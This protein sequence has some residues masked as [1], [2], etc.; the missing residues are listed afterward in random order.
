VLRTLDEVAKDQAT[1]RVRDDVER[2]DL[3]RQTI[4][5]HL[6]VLFGRAADGE[7]IEREHSGHRYVRA[8]RSKNADAA[9]GRNAAAAFENVPW[10]SSNERSGDTGL[11]AANAPAGERVLGDLQPSFFE[12]M[13]FP[14][15]RSYASASFGS[16]RLTALSAQSLTTSTTIALIA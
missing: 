11:A 3:L 15:R 14:R 2:R 4:D 10:M 9:S 12:A 13:L 7:V 6:R 1:T 5:N 16:A 8:T